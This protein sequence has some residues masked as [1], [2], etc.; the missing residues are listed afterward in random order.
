MPPTSADSRPVRRSGM[1]VSSTCRSRNGE[2]TPSAADTRIRPQTA[3]RRR[4]TAGTARRSGAGWP[5]HGLVGGTL[6][7]LAGREPVGTAARHDS[8]VRT[9]RDADFCQQAMYAKRANPGPEALE[10]HPSSCVIRSGAEKVLCGL[11]SN[12]GDRDAHCGRHVVALSLASSASAATVVR[13]WFPQGDQL[14]YGVRAV[15]GRAPV[16]PTT[17]RVA[18]RRPD[19]RRRRVMARE[20]RFARGTR[21]L[22]AA[23]SGIARHHPA[24]PP[25]PAGDR[26]RRGA[27]QSRTPPSEDPRSSDVRSR[28]SP[29]SAGSDCRSRGNCSSS[30]PTWAFA[31]ARTSKGPGPSPSCPRSSRFRL[32]CGSCRATSSIRRRS[33][34]P[35]R[36]SP[37]PAGSTRAR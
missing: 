37:P 16:L 25:L 8:R 27:G 15:E 6:G 23:P 21:L 17:M 36:S 34:S 2:T 1:A 26:R 14:R 28:S 11:L 30:T 29:A 20:P 24:R 13:A 19:A 7:R 33:A 12:T 5:T 9:G 31:G 35:R 3:D 10:S 18:S 22:G 4:R 32:P